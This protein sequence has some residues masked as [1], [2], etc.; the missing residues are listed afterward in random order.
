[1]IVNR[2]KSTIKRIIDRYGERKSNENLRRSGRQRK[3]NEYSGRAIM[4]KIKK[5]PHISAAELQYD[6][7]ISVCN[8][9]IRNYLSS[10]ECHGRIDHRKYYISKVNKSKRLDFAETNLNRPQGF[11]N[12]ML[13]TD[14]MFTKKTR[15]KTK[16]KHDTIVFTALFL[17]V[18]W[19]RKHAQ[20][21]FKFGQHTSAVYDVNMLGE[22]PQTIRENT[23]ILLETSKAISLEVN[24]EKTKYMI[25][26]R[27]QKIVRNGNIKI[28]DLSF[29]EVSK[30]QIEKKISA[31]ISVGLEPIRSIEKRKECRQLILRKL[32]HIRGTPPDTTPMTKENH[33][34][35]GGGSNQTT[36]AGHG[37]LNGKVQENGLH[38][39]LVYA[40]DVN[41]LEENPQIIRENRE[42]HLKQVMR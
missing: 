11:W 23:E 32:R 35:E 25:M 17:P 31:M 7:G 15:D 40:D 1:M 26:S 10:S 19:Q 24:S 37:S 30:Y 34:L 39:L 22:N 21:G 4:R 20:T 27:D 36:S 33:M 12:R 8:S 2:G 3:I 18:T 41:M 38:Q 16:H 29:E 13:F 5:N 42:F 14:E 28:A 9:T 6:L